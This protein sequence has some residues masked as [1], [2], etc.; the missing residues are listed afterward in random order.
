MRGSSIR[1]AV[2]MRTHQVYT[3]PDNPNIDLPAA[4]TADDVESMLAPLVDQAQALADEIAEP[5]ATATARDHVARLV[6]AFD[7]ACSTIETYESKVYLA[8]QQ[9]SDV[10]ETRDAYKAF[11]HSVQPVVDRFTRAFLDALLDTEIVRTHVHDAFGEVYLARVTAWR[12]TLDPANAD[13]E[14]ELSDELMK[15]TELFAA[16]TFEWRGEEHRLTMMAKSLTDPDRAARHAAFAS[17]TKFLQNNH[18]T[19]EQVF[20][21]ACEL[22]ER[23]ADGAGFSSYTDMRYSSMWRIDYDAG[24]VERFR[25]SIYRHVVPLARRL[26]EQQAAGHGT[27]LVHPADAAIADIPVPEMAVEMDAQ[28]AAGSVLFNELD[29]ELGQRYDAM[30]AEGRIDLASR[31]GKATGGFCIS[32]PDDGVPFIFSNSVGTYGDVAVL[33]HECGHAFQSELSAWI[34]PKLLLHPTLE[35]CEVHSMGLELMAHPH[36]EA[37]F[38]PEHADHYRIRDVRGALHSLAYMAAVDEFQHGLYPRAKGATTTGSTA[39]GGGGADARGELWLALAKR[40]MQGIDHEADP[41]FGRHRWLTQRHI[42]H[43][44]FYYIDYALAQV[45]ALQLWK[46]SRADAEDALECY[47]G[48]CTVGGTLP[49]REFVAHAGLSDPFDDD[50]VAAV[51]AEVAAFLGL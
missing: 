22:R 32:F 18:E 9:R 15:H 31:P 39:I 6:N 35:A 40:Y 10:D 47:R 51:A 27:A 11:N 33:V 29:E 20:D 46:R 3:T 37:F 7:A 38:S 25:E 30:V 4:V 5:M 48:L 42:F 13:L 17:Y 26:R 44:P 16:G 45:V 24:D 12:D 21:R 43:T 8:Y 50:T 14:I 34:R 23:I 41:W 2:L 49:L 1:Y 28:L 36:L 19:L